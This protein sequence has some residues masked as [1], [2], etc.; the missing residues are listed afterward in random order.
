MWAAWERARC[1]QPGSEVSPLPMFPSGAL[2]GFQRSAS[3]RGAGAAWA[4][5]SSGRLLRRVLL[6]NAGSRS[7]M[8]ERGRAATR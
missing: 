8:R 4:V 7:L 5:G 3:P 6:H 2:L 1:G